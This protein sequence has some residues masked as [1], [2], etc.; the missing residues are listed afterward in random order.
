VGEGVEG[1]SPP[2]GREATARPPQTPQGPPARQRRPP[3]TRGRMCA[4]KMDGVFHLT[5]E[6]SVAGIEA[7]R[8]A[9]ALTCR[10]LEMQKIPAEI[11]REDFFLSEFEPESYDIVFS[12]GF[13]EHFRDLPPVVGRIRPIARR[14]VVTMAPNLFGLNGMISR[15]IR[16]AVYAD[17]T[18]IDSSLLE[19]LHRDPGAVCGS[20]NLMRG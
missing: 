19:K 18:P 12:A 16:P 6:Y 7:A 14:Y 17:H 13:I 2:G 15:K 20:I 1:I 4:G 5:I 8:E 3:L 9:A 11:R 10:N